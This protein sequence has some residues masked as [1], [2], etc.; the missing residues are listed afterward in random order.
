MLRNSR[1]NL[2]RL[3]RP[4]VLGGGEVY[5]VGSNPRHGCQ[6]VLKGKDAGDAKFPI[7]L[8][9]TKSTKKALV[10]PIPPPSSY[11]DAVGWAAIEAGYRP[12]LR[13]A[14][15]FT[16][17]AVLQF[18]EVNNVRLW[19]DLKKIEKTRQAG[20]SEYT[21]GKYRHRIIV[22]PKRRSL[23]IPPLRDGD[24]QLIIRGAAD[25]LPPGIRQPFI[26]VYVWKRP[27]D[28]LQRATAT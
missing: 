16:R 11:E 27:V 24:V 3:A 10:P 22:E 12:A 15:K 9:N 1:K 18:L 17:E 19:R 14:R 23:H 7:M 4:L 20:V 8:Y 25:A 5:N 21:P 6:A 26:C 13:A 2:M 28:R